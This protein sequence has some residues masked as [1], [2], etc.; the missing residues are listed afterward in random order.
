MDKMP[1]SRKSIKLLL[2]GLIVMAAGY[3]LLSGGGIKDPNVFNYSMF[4]FRRLVAAPVVMVA[5]IV[6]IVV[7]IMRKPKEEE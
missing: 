6:V 4:D 3:V 7:A 1:M 2:A 5:G